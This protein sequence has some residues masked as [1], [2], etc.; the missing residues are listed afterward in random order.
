[1][2]VRATATYTTIIT[3]Q[4]YIQKRLYKANPPSY[5]SKNPSHPNKKDTREK[6]AKITKNP[7]EIPPSEYSNPKNQ[8]RV[9]GMVRK[10]ILTKSRLQQAIKQSKIV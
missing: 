10:A 9:G 3:K 5:R 6:T 4:V 1:M 7:Q 2:K 8:S